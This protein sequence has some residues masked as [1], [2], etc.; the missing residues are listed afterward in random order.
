[1]SDYFEESGYVKT[2]VL[3]E[4]GIAYDEAMRMI[5][6]RKNDLNSQINTLEEKMKSL[7]L[8]LSCIEFSE[9]TLWL[10]YKGGK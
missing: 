2:S 10:S 1:M 7:K 8:E 4:Q 9:R 6:D 5:Y 3:R